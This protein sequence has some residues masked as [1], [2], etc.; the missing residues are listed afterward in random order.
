MAKT[1]AVDVALLK[2]QLKAAIA[3]VEGRKVLASV[4]YQH[5]LGRHI[6]V[7]MDAT[8]M[9]WVW[10]GIYGG[11]GNQPGVWAFLSAFAKEFR[12][13][14]GKIED[15]PPVAY[16]LRVAKAKGLTFRPGRR[17]IYTAE[18]TLRTL[19]ELYG[20]LAIEGAR[21]GEAAAREVKAQVRF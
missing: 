14:H 12:G 10:K 7:A 5:G 8:K 6:P 16:A 17:K 9:T 18:A 1:Y 4:R 19:E 20:D 15:L 2:G 11:H 3:K 13:V 21:R